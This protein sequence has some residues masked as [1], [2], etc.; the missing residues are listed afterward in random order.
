MQQMVVANRLADGAVVFLTPDERWCTWIGDGR[1][2][3]DAA[4]AELALSIARRHETENL[5]VEPA[6]IEVTVA[7]DGR[8]RPVS[9]RESIRAFGPSLGA[10][11]TGSRGASGTRR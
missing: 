9:L 5:V 1:V 2:L 4:E 11:R 10:G 3:D 7:E 8:P 6:L